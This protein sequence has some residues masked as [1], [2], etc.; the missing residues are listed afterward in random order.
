[1]NYEKITSDI[2]RIY[3]KHILKDVDI[4]CIDDYNNFEEEIWALKDKY[5][6]KSSPF[7]CYLNQLN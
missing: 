1:M 7:Y 4:F 6:L 5:Q 3:E 2:K